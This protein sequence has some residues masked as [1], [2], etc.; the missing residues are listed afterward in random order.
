MKRKRLLFIPPLVQDRG[1]TVYPLIDFPVFG[2]VP[3]TICDALKAI[4]TY[5]KPGVSAWIHGLG[6]RVVGKGI[7]WRSNTGLQLYWQ[8]VGGVVD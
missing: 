5:V 7:R 2:P 3:P 4:F 8:S 1:N 6:G